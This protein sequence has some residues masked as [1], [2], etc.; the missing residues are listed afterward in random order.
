MRWLSAVLAAVAGSA[1]MAQDIR[2]SP[3][4]TEACLADAEGHARLDCTGRSADACIDATSDGYTT[5]GMGM[6]LGRERDWWDA[7]LNAAYRALMAESE[8]MDDEMRDFGSAT[9][10]QAPA[11]RDMQRAWIGFR[12]A[13]CA[14]ERSTWGGGTGGAPASVECALDHTAAQALALEDRLATYREQ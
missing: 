13:A 9:P 11:L 1:A 4:A 6:C 14:Y 8:R 5:V 3:E 2:F 7:R 12:D 10:P